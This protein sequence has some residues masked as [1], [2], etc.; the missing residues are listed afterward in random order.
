MFC[1][2]SSRNFL[3]GTYKGDVFDPLDTFLIASR[4]GTRITMCLVEGVKELGH[5]LKPH[6]RLYL[7]ISAGSAIVPMGLLSTR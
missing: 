1:H 7:P 3:S 6:V 5:V 4:R 2:S